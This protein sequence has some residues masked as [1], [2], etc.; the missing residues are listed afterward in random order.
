MDHLPVDAA[1][2]AGR[3][4][5]WKAIRTDDAL[6]IGVT[7]TAGGERQCAEG[8]SLQIYVEPTR[9]QPRR[10]FHISPDGSA[11]CQQDDGYIP[12]ENAGWTVATKVGKREWSAVLRIPLEWLGM[13]PGR[14]PRALRVNIIR[15]LPISGAPGGAECSW[16][17]REPAQ[18]RLVWGDL[19]PATDF[20]W[21]KPQ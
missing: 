18:G 6:L 13:K 2:Y 5:T 9:T 19:N 20:G 11:R 4:A 17:R 7:C 8:E 15:Q 3:T 10:I 14:K 21:L 16:A 12:R 1:E